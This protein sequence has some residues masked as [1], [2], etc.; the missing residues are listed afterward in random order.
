MSAA[1]AC[2]LGDS[3]SAGLADTDV[4]VLAPEL[5]GAN[6]RPVVEVLPPRPDGR[7]LDPSADPQTPLG[8]LRAQYFPVWT[9]DFDAAFPPQACGSAWEL[10][11]IAEP[12]A[13]VNVSLYGDAPTM[14]A[15]AVMR[16]E[17]LVTR[18][19]ARPSPLAQLCVAVGSVDPARAEVLAHVGARLDGVGVGEVPV[20]FPPEV[21]ILAASP[22][23]MLAVACIG[24]D[25]WGPQASS[26]TAGS[27]EAGPH[28]AR[29]SAYL[30][31][32][33]QGRED[34]VVDVSYR[35]SR[36]YSRVAD[37][38]SGIGQ[39]TAEWDQQVQAWISEGQ[40]WV[41][42]RESLSAEAICDSPPA[43]GPQECPAT[44][45]R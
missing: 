36:A 27:A 25:A 26:A 38:C 35:V 3:S 45:A 8:R 18:A 40:A 44:W 24:P 42:H 6:G 30:L 5:A 32:I 28:Q 20:G 33:S 2:S 16:Y 23:A 43:E 1:V 17:H 34:Q 9:S 11:A 4:G 22:T 12:V 31:L 19:L 14:A 41:P 10:D 39:W 29:L 13:H 15:L 37:D 7:P 21:T